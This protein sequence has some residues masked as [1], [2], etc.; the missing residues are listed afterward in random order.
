MEWIPV[1]EKPSK[2]PVRVLATVE[3]VKVRKP[4]VVDCSYMREVDPETGEILGNPTFMAFTGEKYL[5]LNDSN[6]FRT[7][8]WMPMPEPYKRPGLRVIVTGSNSF[9]NYKLMCEKLDKMFSGSKPACILYGEG[10]GAD[11]LAK[12]Y[13]QEHGIKFEPY[14]ADW[15]GQ[16]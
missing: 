8:A 7:T 6:P 2:E 12:K 14:Y 16:G 11:L 10:Q 5:N 1:S 3:D 13:A 9:D 4:Y 15:K